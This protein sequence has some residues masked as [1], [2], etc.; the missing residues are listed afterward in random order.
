MISIHH[1]QF[2]LLLTTLNIVVK[3]HPGKWWHIPLM[4]ALERQRHAD[5]CEFYIS[6]VNRVITGSIKTTLGNPVIKTC[7]FHLMNQLI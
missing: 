7:F 4:P 2:F 3:F 6:L 5:I 1:A